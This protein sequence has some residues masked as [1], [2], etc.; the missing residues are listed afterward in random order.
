MLKVKS[1]YSVLIV[2]LLCGFIF[3]SHHL[4]STILLGGAY[5]TPLVSRDVNFYTLEET[6]Y[7][8]N[9]RD[10]YDGHLIVTDSQIYENKDQPNV[11]TPWFTY[12]VLGLMAMLTGSVENTFIIG[13]FVFP[14]LTFLVL[15]FTINRAT[16]NHLVGILGGVAVL[17]ISYAFALQSPEFYT[18]NLI[19]FNFTRLPYYLG[20]LPFTEFT[21]LL[22]IS[23]ILF[24]YL[25][26]ETRKKRF[27]L[28]AGLLGGMQ[29]YTYVFNIFAIAIGLVFLFLFYLIRKDL[30]NAKIIF[31]IG[32]IAFLIGLPYII[33]FVTIRLS[34]G[35]SEF[36]YKTGV[37][38]GRFNPLFMLRTI[39]YG[40]MIIPFL[41]LK[42]KKPVHTILLLFYATGLIGLNLQLL[43]GYTIQPTHYWFVILEPLGVIL[44]VIYFYELF[45]KKNIVKALST[46]FVNKLV[47]PIHNNFKTITIV[48]T[49]G[50][51]L[52]GILMHASYAILTYKDFTLSESQRELFAWLDNNTEKD[53]VVMT[54]NPENNILL[55]V[56]THNNVFLPNAL[57]SMTPVNETFE[58]ML[59][60]F[61][62]FGVTPEYLEWLLSNEYTNGS[63]RMY[64]SLK[65]E[66]YD[67]AVL[68]YY[69]FHFRHIFDV[70]KLAY[71]TNLPREYV[72]NDIQAR[73][74]DLNSIEAIIFIPA[75]F[76]SKMLSDY[77]N[78]PDDVVELSESYRVDYVVGGPY[79]NSVG[80]RDFEQSGLV[81][82]WSNGEYA[83][84]R[85]PN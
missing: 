35:Y 7:A 80:H 60:A 49:A 48:L 34:E 25:S 9:I 57:N 13:D 82:V 50:L 85:I 78:Y 66:N 15:Y 36:L 73:G 31:S 19:P 18:Q 6:M 62:T 45:Y 54:L 39:F 51:L 12:F 23:T 16:Q 64:T 56:Y 40:F 42:E 55:P 41:M 26:I 3:S 22:L 10:V 65:P 71:D 27:V 5:Y 11:L 20:R 61:K 37:Y 21:F 14:A 70:K 79:E 58:R 44:G 75:D 28:I 76:R 32:L 77:L 81:K 17:F 29:F 53:T 2:A 46:N 38:Y 1:K 4:L 30:G 68:H 67:K 59:I 84:Y 69:L 74:L 8:S 83:V 47:S 33:Q 63:L 72:L 43:V 24:T 52:H